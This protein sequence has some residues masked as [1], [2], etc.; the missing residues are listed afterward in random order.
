[1]QLE[2]RHALCIETQAAYV[3]LCRWLRWRWAALHR[4][5]WG[6]AAWAGTLGGNAYPEIPPGGSRGLPG[7]GEGRLFK[8]KSE[9]EEE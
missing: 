1:M 8:A 6:G 3:M 9:E 2:R 5:P 7:E 4:C